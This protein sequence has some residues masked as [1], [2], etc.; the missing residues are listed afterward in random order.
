M[1][2]LTRRTNES[3]MIGNEAE[4]KI[5]ILSIKGNQVRIGID[6]PK[7]ISVHREEIYQRICAD[8]SQG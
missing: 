2:I 1:L 6:A 7:E 8:K 5:S 3:I 4:I